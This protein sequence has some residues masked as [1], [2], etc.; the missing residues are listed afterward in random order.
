MEAFLINGPAGK[1]EAILAQIPKKPIGIAIVAHPHPLFGG[2]MDNKVTH[3]LF[4]TFH[5]LGFITVKFNFRGVGNSEGVHDNGI[6]EVDDVV[7]VTRA[8]QEHVRSQTDKSCLPLLLAGFSFGG[9]IQLHAAPHLRPQSLVLIA[10]SVMMS[11][12]P[13]P[14]E[15]IKRIL[16]IHGDKDDVVPLDSLLDWAT[17]RTLPIVIIPGAEHFFHGKLITLKQ[18]IRDFFVPNN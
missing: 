14:H 13:L 6:G 2:T 4:K 17:P 16:I 11:K 3:T 12:A 5:E 8:I 15:G 1:I 18:T 7:A 10:P 9:G